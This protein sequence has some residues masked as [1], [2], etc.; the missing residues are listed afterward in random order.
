M[1]KHIIFFSLLLVTIS[2]SSNKDLTSS[3]KT[4]KTIMKQYPELP[5]AVQERIVQFQKEA[6]TNPP[7][8]IYQYQYH[9]N[10][11]Y[12]ITAPCCDFYSELLNEKGKIICH[13]DGGFTGK[14]D[15]KC[16]DFNKT[17]S[18]EKLIWKDNRKQ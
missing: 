8:A 17:K 3:N 6:K 12:Y 9:N 1:M 10:T 13:P 18:N 7:R 4:L 15:G 16:V 14:G 2:C 11:V 5:K